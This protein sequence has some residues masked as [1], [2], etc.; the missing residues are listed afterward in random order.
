[1]KRREFVAAAASVI[2]VPSVSSSPYREP[3]YLRS[4]VKWVARNRYE[5]GGGATLPSLMRHLRNVEPALN[6]KDVDLV[7]AASELTCEGVWSLNDARRY[8]LAEKVGLFALE[9]A[10]RAGDTNAQS[11]AYSALSAI[12]TDR[13]RLDHAVRYAQRGLKLRDVDHGQ[14]AWLGLRLAWATSSIR[15][16]EISTLRSIDGIR[17]FVEEAESFGMP[18]F[19]KADMIGGVG[20][21]LRGVGTTL[22]S[23]GLHGEAAR[24]LSD[25]VKM[26]QQSAMLLEESSMLLSGFYLT[27]EIMTILENREPV[28]A[29]EKMARLA[30]IVPFVSSTRMDEN[31]ANILASSKSWNDVPE[32]RSAREQLRS[33]IPPS[34]FGRR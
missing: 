18:A 29:A 28:L 25:S 33:I 2:F 10:R 24:A 20:A 17:S 5:Q 31:V 32:M 15:G 22:R 3:A 19:E 30:R 9:L 12:N 14:H 26:A 8:D 1:M 4:L 16:D 13:G 27:Q 11:R 23:S 21:A 7:R 6:S 34:V